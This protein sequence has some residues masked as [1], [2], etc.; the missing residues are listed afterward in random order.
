MPDDDFSL[1]DKMRWGYHAVLNQFRTPP[2]RA[3]I[4]AAAASIHASPGGAAAA[5]T[6]MCLIVFPGT[7][8]EDYCRNGM[9]NDACQNLAKSVGGFSR[10]VIPGSVCPQ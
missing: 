6:G 4:D 7:D 9:T 5:A 2:S 10:T 8:K 3:E 1:F